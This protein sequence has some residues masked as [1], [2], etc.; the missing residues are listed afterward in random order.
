[1]TCR[2]SPCTFSSRVIGR[3][4]QSGPLQGV[5]TLG[6]IGQMALTVSDHKC[7]HYSDSVHTR[8]L[9][10]DRSV[11]KTGIRALVSRPGDRS[12]AE[13]RMPIEFIGMIGVRPEG[14]DGAAVHVIG[15]EIDRRWV[16]DFSRAHEVAGFDKV[17]VG[18][19]STAAEGFMVSSYAAALTERLAFLIAHRPGFVAPTLAA[20]KAATLDQFTGGRGA[21]PHITAGRA[22]PPP[23]GGPVV[24]PPTPHPRA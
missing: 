3:S 16:R 20:R 12:P 5:V 11:E 17:L 10:G 8:A 9:C 15:G 18:Y 23:Q 14:A 24:A 6:T 2:R 21:P 4:S 13:E 1:M 7:Q 19:T 22:P